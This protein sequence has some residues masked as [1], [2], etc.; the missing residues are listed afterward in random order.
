MTRRYFIDVN[1]G[2]IVGSG[3]VDSIQFNDRFVVVN[4]SNY[5]LHL[6]N[7]SPVWVTSIYNA[8]FFRSMEEAQDWCGPT[9]KVTGV[10]L[11]RID[12]AEGPK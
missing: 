11:T 8:T 9:D 1:D 12:E 3:T 5:Y 2:V 6:V 4:P 7:M 10:C